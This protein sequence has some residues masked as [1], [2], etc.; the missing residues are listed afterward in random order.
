MQSSDLTATHTAVHHI[1]Y[2]TTGYFS[3]LVQDY[4][5]GNEQ[6]NG[7]YRFS[8]D[9]AGIRKA[10][11]ARQSFSTDRET[12]VTVLKAQYRHL[13][14]ST[15]LQQQFEALLQ[16][17]TY[18][19]TTAHQPNIL[20]GPLYFIYKII[21]AIQLAETLQ[22]EFPQHHFVPVY[23]MGSEDAD[24]DELGH[25]TVDGKRYQWKTPQTG[26]VG[27]MKVDKAFLQLLKELESQ[28]AV[29]P[30]GA[31]LMRLFTDVY[32]E[33]ISLQQA[34]LT[35]VNQLFGAYGLVVLIPD[36]RELKRLFIPV[37]EKE[38][39]EQFSHAAV[40]TA[41]DQLATHYKVQAAGRD[42]NLFYLTDEHRERIEKDGDRF[43]VRA[44]K[45]EWSLPDILHE[46]H[47]YPERFSANVILRGVFQETILP[48]I[49]FIGGGGEL[50]YWLEL[51]PVFE[52]TRVPY[53]VLLLRNSFLLIT[54]RQRDQFTEMGF[55]LDDLFTPAESLL[56]SLVKKETNHQL[57]LSEE[58]G[59]LNLFYQQLHETANAID[60]TLATHVNALQA[61][62]LKKL[63]AL[64]K[65]LLRA[66]KRKFNEA[67]QRINKIKAVLFPGDSL[68]ERVENM[69]GWYGRY[70]NDFIDLIYRYSL[71]LEQQFTVITI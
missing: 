30:H 1:D 29:L 18:T 41:I 54:Q 2:A 25:F 71:S 60:P 36:N 43:F 63:L 34:T 24:L 69:S 66:E 65:K 47:E 11:E 17:G 40:Q 4:L 15:R 67:G 64:E 42:L 44:L 59:E 37:V 58:A 48:N 56:N 26:A 19:I 53:P 3:R 23:Y 70:G 9:I 16:P 22:K 62:A 46:L 52:S 68:Q 38:L 50:A 5:K 6:L 55:T 13:E 51:L 57:S 21:H 33:G 31:E 20:T 45:I 49:A 27:R 14:Q 61:Q 32:Q 39:K 7:L 8:P 12:L 35:L 28:L 10:I